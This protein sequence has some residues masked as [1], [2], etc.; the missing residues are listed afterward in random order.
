MS[1]RHQY[2]NDEVM[3][4]YF[5]SIMPEKQLDEDA[6]LKCEGLFTVNECKLAISKIKKNKSPGLYGIIVEFYETFWPLIG[7]LLISVFNDS[8]EKEILPASQRIS[9]FTL[10][11][12]KNDACDLANY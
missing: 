7:D 10:I 5:D 12:K 3:S 6:L 11:F 2:S 4:A 1:N 9:V 8:Y